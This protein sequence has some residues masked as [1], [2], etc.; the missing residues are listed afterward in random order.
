MTMWQISWWEGP[1]HSWQVRLMLVALGQGGG[2]GA[3]LKMD[4]DVNRH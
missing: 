3:V 4:P 1:E 2:W